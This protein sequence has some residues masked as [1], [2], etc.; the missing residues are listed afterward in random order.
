MENCSFSKNKNYLF[1]WTNLC[2]PNMID[3]QLS[4][5][6][7]TVH[8][9]HSFSPSFAYIYIIWHEDM[10]HVKVHTKKK[11]EINHSMIQY[12]SQQRRFLAYL[13][14]PPLPHQD[15]CRKNTHIKVHCRAHLSVWFSVNLKTAEGTR[16]IW[17][18]SCVIFQENWILRPQ[19]YINRIYSVVIK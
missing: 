14:N 13:W 4:I 16:F 7:N 10:F 11:K 17:V 2:K 12:Y 5:L 19:L 15:I 9:G 6:K 1:L 18:K 8:P 3:Q